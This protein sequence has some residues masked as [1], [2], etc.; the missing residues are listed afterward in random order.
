M[1][2]QIGSALF[3]AK[4]AVSRAMS[5][6]AWPGR[7]T[8]L[9]GGIRNIISCLPARVPPTG[10]PSTQPYRLRPTDALEYLPV[11]GMDPRPPDLFVFM[12]A[13]DIMQL[14]RNKFVGCTLQDSG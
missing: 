10:L 6:A 12:H 2:C 11:L 14:W 13:N 3:H 8:Q 9:P 4:R 1:L 7:G 5:C